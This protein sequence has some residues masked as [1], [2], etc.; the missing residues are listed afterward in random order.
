[1]N[2]GVVVS[3]FALRTRAPRLEGQAKC[4]TEAKVKASARKDKPYPC[5]RMI[6]SPTLVVEIIKLEFAAERKIGV[7]TSLFNAIMLCAEPLR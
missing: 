7:Q 1:M 2:A 6:L 5:N 4:K 3:R